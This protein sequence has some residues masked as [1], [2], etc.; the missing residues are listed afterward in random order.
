MSQENTKIEARAYPIAEPKGTTLAFASINIDDKFAVN[1]IR[2]VRSE[3]G[4]FVAMPQT[5]D[6]KGEYR[7][8]CFPV[9]KEL[10]QQINDAVLTEYSAAK[11]TLVTQKESTVE[12]LRAAATAAKERPPQ[13]KAKSAAKHAGAEL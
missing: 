10:R 3:K 2:V 4:P 1:G 6:A 7:D 12:K 8:V 13:A 11:D 5:R 9:T